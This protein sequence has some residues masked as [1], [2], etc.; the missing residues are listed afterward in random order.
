[1]GVNNGKPDG[2]LARQSRRKSMKRRLAVLA[3]GFC[4]MLSGLL[5]AQDNPFVGT[6]KL[7]TAKSKFEPGRQLKSMTRTIV[8]QGNGATYSYCRFRKF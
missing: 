5:L 1:M 7:N 2:F 4:T 6:W 8:A 3:F